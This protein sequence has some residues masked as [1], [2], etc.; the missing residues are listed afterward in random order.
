MS[1]ALNKTQ[2]VR[3][4]LFC[5][6]RNRGNTAQAKHIFSGFSLTFSTFP[7]FSL[8]IVKFPD[9]SRFSRLVPTQRTRWQTVTAVRIT[10]TQENTHTNRQIIEL[11]LQYAKIFYKPDHTA[12]MFFHPRHG[13]THI[14]YGGWAPQSF[15]NCTCPR[16]TNQCYLCYL[17]FQIHFICNCN[18]V[19]T[20]STANDKSK[21]NPITHMMLR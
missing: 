3:L 16:P 11:Q 21:H 17:S 19:S 6:H 5:D 15:S 10:D 9:F 4:C 20:A 13:F 14:S 1:S 7:D 12:A 18:A 8:T 2:A